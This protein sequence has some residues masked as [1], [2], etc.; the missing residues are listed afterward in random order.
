MTAKVLFFGRSPRREK[1][2]GHPFR[3]EVG[4]KTVPHTVKKLR[5]PVKVVGNSVLERFAGLDVGRRNWQSASSARTASGGV[6]ECH[7]QSVASR[8]PSKQSRTSQPVGSK[9]SDGG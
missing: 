2:G 1:W 9:N 3:Y 6:T 7:S 5:R 8:S 4:T